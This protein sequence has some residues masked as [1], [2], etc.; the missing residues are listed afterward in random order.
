MKSKTRTKWLGCFITEANNNRLKDLAAKYNLSR[1]EMIGR[2]LERLVI[3]DPSKHRAVQ[4]LCSV[5]GKLNRLNA[6]LEKGGIGEGVGPQ[7][8]D[9]VARDIRST[10]DEIKAVLLELRDQD[11]GHARVTLRQLEGCLRK[12]RPS[13]EADGSGHGPNP[14]RPG[15]RPGRT[16]GELTP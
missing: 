6:L 11:P 16:D 2:I 3:P 10:I 7:S 5:V 8:G 14:S 4:G 9:A 12:G 1:T 15:R 13:G